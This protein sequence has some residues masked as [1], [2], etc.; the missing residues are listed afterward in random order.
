MKD[1]NIA[2]KIHVRIHVVPIEKIFMQ[3]MTLD[4]SC[5]YLLTLQCLQV[6][7]SPHSRL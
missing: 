1:V 4:G 5:W 6:D 7:E 2:I 3:K